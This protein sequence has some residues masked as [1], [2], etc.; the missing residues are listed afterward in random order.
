MLAAQARNYGLGR[1]VATQASKGLHSQIPGN[2]ATQFFG[3]LNAPV[4][5]EAAREMVRS[6]PA[7]CQAFPDSAAGSSTSRLRVSRSERRGLRCASVT[8]PRALCPLRRVVPSPKVITP[9]GLPVT[10]A[11]LL[12][13]P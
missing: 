1:V 8:V 4:H 11:R 7:T 3:L 9:D 12:F 5:I 2:A 13:S 10:R 6:T